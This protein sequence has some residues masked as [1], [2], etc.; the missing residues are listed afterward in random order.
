MFQLCVFILAQVCVFLP[1]ARE[2]MEVITITRFPR[3]KANA[4]TLADALQGISDDGALVRI[5][6]EV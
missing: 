5:Y 1:S 3:G 6:R 2:E 4:G